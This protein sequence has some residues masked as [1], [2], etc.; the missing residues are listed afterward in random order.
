[1]GRWKYKTTD[2][3]KTE[4]CDNPASTFIFSVENHPY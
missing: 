2:K 4:G 1:M 3:C